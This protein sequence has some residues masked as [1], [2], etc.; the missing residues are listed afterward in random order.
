[1]KLSVA[2][3]L[4]LLSI[5]LLSCNNK[6]KKSNDVLK[7]SSSDSVGVEPTTSLKNNNQVSN[8]IYFK[9]SGNEP[10]WGLEISE[11][12]IKLTTIG[13]SIVTPHTAAVRA[14][15]ANVKMYKV[16]TESNEMTIQIME[17]ECTDTMSGAV[18]PYTVTIDYRKNTDEEL[19]TLHGCG[20]YI[21]DYRLHDIWVLEK[22]NG[23]D[24]TKED[25]SKELPTMEIN[26]TANT[27]SGFAGCNRMN[28]SL[29]S[30]KELL[31]FTN[32]ATTKMMCEP[33][34]KEPEFIKAL[35]SGTTYKIAN[36]RLMLSNPEGELLV[37]KKID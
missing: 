2:I 9:A 34:N 21:T 8:D 33:A 20:R 3:P 36:N 16:Q 19:T 13:D 23:N 11:N 37:F 1:M 10:F 15:D 12:G 17:S 32:I 29:F 18:S 5:I 25:F 26:S 14:M 27:F 22:I 35:Q 6:A 30:E 4:F 31:R 7:T 28:G 24:I